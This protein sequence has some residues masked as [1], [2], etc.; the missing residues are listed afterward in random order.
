MSVRNAPTFTFT[1]NTLEARVTASVGAGREVM[2]GAGANSS[3]AGHV[4]E[5]RVTQETGVH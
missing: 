2:N 5:G 4:F 3:G 1:V